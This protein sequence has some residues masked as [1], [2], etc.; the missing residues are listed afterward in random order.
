MW[1]GTVV[2]GVLAAGVV[3][4]APTAFPLVGGL[5]GVLVAAA[6]VRRQWHAAGRYILAG[7]A[8]AAVLAG[9]LALNYATTGMA[10]ISP[11]RP[12]WRHADQTVFSRWVSPYLMTLL[13][14]GSAAGM[15]DVQLVNWEGS[16][17]LEFV[18]QLVRVRAA[19]FFVLD[20]LVS[21]EYLVGGWVAGLCLLLVR[22]RRTRLD[23]GQAAIPVVGTLAV[24]VGLSQVANQPVSVYRYFSFTIFFT[25]AAPT[26]GWVLV[27]R[28]APSRQ[29]VGLTSYIL[30]TVVVGA[31]TYH[32]FADV[33]TD[34]YDHAVKF[35]G[36]NVSLADAYRRRGAVSEPAVAYRK[37]IGTA[38][39]VYTFNLNDYS[40]SPGA[41]VESFV[42]FGLHQDWHT[43]MFE[44]PAAARAALQAQRLDYFVINFK[45]R[46]IDV[47][48]YAPLFR[49]ENLAQ[50]F[51]VAWTDGDVYLL[52]WAGPGT[53]PLPESFFWRY[54]D[55]HFAGTIDLKP[56]YDQ[57]ARIYAANRGRPYP[58]V[59]DPNLPR[60][61]GW[62]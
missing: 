52:T 6:V 61:K 18:A 46:V 14:E 36:G 48:Q 16:T 8:A 31:A 1:T 47:L 4:F 54:T 25:V 43:V 15:G 12:F 58:V 13:E 28:L 38:A 56:L 60:V 7:S 40:M 27:F 33:P 39:R 51:A 22:G 10:E 37:Q 11:F 19:R 17:R 50:N 30:P 41:E 32:G 26:L 55:E 34:E 5:L 20:G 44:P 49:P 3:L 2:T 24:A 45:S 9:L 42:S 59:R 29:W 53:T 57:V 23:F 21:P 35:A 62:Q